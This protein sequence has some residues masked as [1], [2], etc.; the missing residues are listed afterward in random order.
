[1][2]QYKFD[3]IRE[4][5][6]KWN[7]NIPKT[8]ERMEQLPWDVLLPWIGFDENFKMTI[9]F[10]KDHY[11]DEIEDLDEWLRQRDEYIRNLAKEYETLQNEGR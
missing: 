5:V 2:K 11:G 9:T 8:V 6:E 4:W 10:A 1:M 7:P 3:Y